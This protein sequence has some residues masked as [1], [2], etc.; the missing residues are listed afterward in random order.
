M[1]KTFEQPTELT[2]DSIIGGTI[3]NFASTG[4]QDTASELTLTVTDGKITVDTVAAKT[5]EVGTINGNTVIR[6]DVKIYGI[7]DAGFVRT[8]EVITNQRYEK[9]YLEFAL[10]NE[11]GTNIGT[12][13]LWPGAPYN[14]QFVLRNNPDRFFVSETIDLGP[15]KQFLINGVVAVDSQYLGSS[16]VNSNL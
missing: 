5:L 6:G 14:K 10:D 12:G 9:Q 7:L 3:R 13:L 8:T 4:I 11:Q 2:G 16:I 15:N 1:V